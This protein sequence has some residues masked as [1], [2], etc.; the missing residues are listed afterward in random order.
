MRQLWDYLDGELTDERMAQVRAH[1]DRCSGCYPHYD[2]EK[3]LLE[4]LACCKVKQ[5]APDQL[6]DRILG[7]LREAGFVER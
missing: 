6:R 7:K 1:L 3:M 4:A 2:F 5:C